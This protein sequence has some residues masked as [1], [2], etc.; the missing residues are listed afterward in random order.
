[1]S[2][3]RVYNERKHITMNPTINN[4][5]TINVVESQQQNLPQ[6][7]EDLQKT[8]R[9][10]KKQLAKLAKELGNAEKAERVLNCA[11]FL[12]YE[13]INQ[14]YI[15]LARIN[16]CRERLCLN[17]QLA[18]SR[19]L[20]RQLF[21]SLPRLKIKTDENLQFVTLT[22]QNCKAEKLK[23]TIQHMV[24]R[25]N[26]MFRHF[27][28][29]DYFRSVEITYNQNTNDFHP[30]LHLTC[31]VN[32]NSGFPFFEPEKGK[33]GANKLQKTWYEWLG[34]PNEYGY[35]LA[36]T[37][38]IKTTRALYEL[39]KY[40]SKVENLENIKVLKVFN[41]QLKGLRLKTPSGQF[42][43]LASAYKAE[44]ETIKL[45]ELQY[46]DDAEIQLIELIYSTKKQQYVLKRITEKKIVY[47]NQVNFW[48]NKR[49]TEQKLAGVYH[50]NQ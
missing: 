28:I 39:C 30:H 18:N 1:M 2:P 14:E 13:L 19:E 25:Q 17:C 35:N 29:T 37:Y 48:Q 15:K 44:C 46:L 4:Y 10:N 8:H 12:T 45:Q 43:S 33:K 47:S 41:E 42:K 27:K 34:I 16:R 11:N 32:K 40:I 3:H 36:T 7:Y 26:A 20:I 50:G 24:K 38:E 6:F 49:I 31:I 5:N 21:W 9:K 22:A 23:E